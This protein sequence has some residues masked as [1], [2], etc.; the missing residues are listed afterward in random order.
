MS[1]DAGDRMIGTVQFLRCAGSLATGEYPVLSTD[2]DYTTY[3]I[4]S[5]PNCKY[6]EDLQQRIVLPS[7]DG[8]TK[9]NIVHL[10]NAGFYWITDA[11]KSSIADNAT[12]FALE[13]NAPMTML[14]LGMSINGMWLHSPIDFT[15]WKQIAP[16]SGTVSTERTVA[17][18]RM[19]R[20]FHGEP[21]YPVCWVSITTTQSLKY[22]TYDG[23][24]IPSSQGFNIYAFPAMLWEIEFYNYRIVGMSGQ[25]YTGDEAIFPT[26]S[27]FMAKMT[28]MGFTKETVV[29]ISVSTQCPYDYSWS[30][31]DSPYFILT[32]TNPRKFG[33][34]ALYHVAGY[35]VDTTS[36]PIVEPTLKNESITI[37]LTD[38]EYKCGSVGIT[39][40]NGA[41]FLNIPT[42]WFDSSDHTLS[43]VSSVHADYGQ[44]FRHFEIADNVYS[45]A[46]PH[47]PY[48]ADEWSS[49]RAYSMSFDRQSME[50]SID[51]AHEQLDTQT[52]AQVANTAISTVGSLLSGNIAGAVT[53]IANTA[54]SAATNYRM[55][56]ISDNQARFQQNLSERRIQTQPASAYNISYG[57]GQLIT[58]TE[59]PISVAVLMPKGFTQSLMD[60]YIENFGY[61]NEGEYAMTIQE[62]FYQGTIYSSSTWTGIQFDALVTALH[63][64]IHII[65]LDGRG[66]TTELITEVTG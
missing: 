48:L 13:F 65:G 58:V 37:T 42:E 3:V 2:E 54:I 12:E 28:D 17:L 43:I 30:T 34:Y 51:Y 4:Q 60:T 32:G 49:Y 62:G 10:E 16:V 61:S 19:M 15:P 5:Y 29:D 1:A 36:D 52:K 22:T 18:P 27:Q 8:W 41:V 63:K 23:T 47:I 9:A 44:M 66:N 6:T 53:G 20:P 56:D 7:F 46:E 38:A 45:L 11:R 64:G 25:Y 39:D 31:D 40:Y 14:S 50:K 24:T 26:I 59:Y 21:S 35:I 33:N 57:I 55:Q